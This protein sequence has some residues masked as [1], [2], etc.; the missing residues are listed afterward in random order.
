MKVYCIYVPAEQIVNSG[1]LKRVIGAFFSLFLYAVSVVAFCGMQ[2]VIS[3]FSIFAVSMIQQSTPNHLL[4]KV[5]AYTSAI[6]MC[7]QPVGQMEN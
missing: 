7:A 1:G 2:I 4:G 6:T 5:M 3:I